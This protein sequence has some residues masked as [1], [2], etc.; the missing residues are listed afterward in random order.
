MRINSIPGVKCVCNNKNVLCAQS[1]AW[2]FVRHPVISKLLEA[3]T[4]LKLTRFIHLK[5]SLLSWIML[6]Y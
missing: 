4:K 5:V 3:E 1:M 2:H 6:H